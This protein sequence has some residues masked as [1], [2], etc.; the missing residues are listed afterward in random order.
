M[1]MHND[2]TLLEQTNVGRDINR[3]YLTPAEVESALQKPVVGALC[4][5]INIRNSCEAFSGEF[6]VAYDDN[7]LTLTWQQ[8]QSQAQLVV[9]LPRLQAT[10]RYSDHGDEQTFDLAAQL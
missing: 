5:L 10:I 7:V 2:M 9:D 1:A 4:Q 6:N 3:P 8:R